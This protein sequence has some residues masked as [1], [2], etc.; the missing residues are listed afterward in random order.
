ME[1]G[2]IQPAQGGDWED[3]QREVVN[4]EDKISRMLEE[5][6]ARLE[7]LRDEKNNIRSIKIFSEKDGSL[8]YF[9]DLEGLSCFES[10]FRNDN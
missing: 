2:D 1:R 4:I 9:K 8:L 10:K 7:C 6:E 5:G 3:F